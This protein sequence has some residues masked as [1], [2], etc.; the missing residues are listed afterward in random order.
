MGALLSKDTTPEVE[1]KQVDLW[2]SMSPL[3][4]ARLTVDLSRS[5]CELALAGIRARHPGAG[6]REQLIRL[7]EVTLGPTAT[8]RIYPDAVD[9]L[10]R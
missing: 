10:E 3:E 8:L 4:K 2:R 5:V 9:L 6:S 7:A 1:L